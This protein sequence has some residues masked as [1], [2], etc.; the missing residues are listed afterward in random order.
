M[1]LNKRQPSRKQVAY[2]TREFHWRNPLPNSNSPAVKRT[3]QPSSRFKCVVQAPVP[4]SQSS[5][6]L[7]LPGELLNEIYRYA[8]Q[9][10]EVEVIAK[11]GG[12]TFYLPDGG[13]KHNQMK[14]A[15][16]QIYHETKNF[17][18][19]LNTLRFR[20]PRD[21]LN[22]LDILT[23]QEHS[24]L[25]RINILADFAVLPPASCARYLS[26]FCH[27]NPNVCVA[28]YSQKSFRNAGDYECL[29]KQYDISLAFRKEF[30]QL[31]YEADYELH[32]SRDRVERLARDVWEGYSLPAPPLPSNFVV[33]PSMECGKL[34]MPLIGPKQPGEKRDT[35]MLMVWWRNGI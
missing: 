2:L 11:T 5:P 14:A 24:L 16:R 30:V 25:T 23:P 34:S 1:F 35:I 29:Y 28:I 3:L 10:D 17:G 6:L 21:C 33:F 15:C 8:F 4:L 26:R 13:P 27:D 22:F 12:F 9:V 19:G 18:L 20:T 31:P 7:N 32:V